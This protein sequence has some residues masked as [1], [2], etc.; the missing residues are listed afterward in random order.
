MF[1]FLSSTLCIFRHFTQL[2]LL[3]N[4][5]TYI[6]SFYFTKF[7]C[8]LASVDSLGTTGHQ[9]CIRDHIHNLSRPSCCLIYNYFFHLDLETSSFMKRDPCFSF[10]I[11]LILSL[12]LNF[13]Y[14][15]FYILSF[16]FTRWYF[17]FSFWGDLLSIYVVF[18]MII[19]SYNDNPYP[20]FVQLWSNQRFIWS[21]LLCLL[22]LRQFPNL[23]LLFVGGVSIS[24]WVIVFKSDLSSFARYIHAIWFETIFFLAMIF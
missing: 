12:L 18:G 3:Q 24:W 10:P 20:F 22:L 13:P 14:I 1:L 9:K 15:I 6:F 11:F 2:Q 8:L 19:S 4:D 17:I 16:L 21:I 5:R 7:L 23:F